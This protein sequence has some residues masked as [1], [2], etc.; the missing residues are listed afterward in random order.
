MWSRSELRAK[1]KALSNI[2]GVVGTN[3]KSNP[4]IPAIKLIDPN[5]IKLTRTIQLF[6][7][8]DFELDRVAFSRF[9]IF[10]KSLF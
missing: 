6:E 10:P 4:I 1:Q 7:T 9:Q 5:R 8:L 3:G 2:K